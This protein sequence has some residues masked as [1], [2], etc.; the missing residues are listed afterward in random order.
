[1]RYR[2]QSLDHLRACLGRIPDDV[3]VEVERGVAVSAE[4]VADLRS[5]SALLPGLGDVG[6]GAPGLVAG[7]R[8]AAER[9]RGPAGDGRAMI[10]GK[11]GSEIK[12]FASDDR[13]IK[14]GLSNGFYAAT[15][16]KGQASG[17]GHEP[18]LP[19]A[20]KDL[21]DRVKITIRD[22]GTG[23]TPEIRE[24]M[25]TPFFTTKPAG[26]GTG[27]GLSI[28]HDIIVKQTWWVYQGGDGARRAHRV[29]NCPS[30]RR[31]AVRL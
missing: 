2:L 3:R 9:G 11:K 21:G 20:T 10:Y 1:M 19:A 30:A 16:R 29:Q 13:Y 26:E 12:R 25:F 31:C 17:H 27:L 4:T 6:G 5:L 14:S 23:I 7:S 28:S 18:T 22:N 24:N 8:L 15:K